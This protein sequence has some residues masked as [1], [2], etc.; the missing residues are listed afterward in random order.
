MSP[1]KFQGSWHQQDVYTLVMR[2]VDYHYDFFHYLLNEEKAQ[3]CLRDVKM[4]LS[5]KAGGVV[6]CSNHYSSLV[7]YDR[8]IYVSYY[9]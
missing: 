5:K 8:L 3:A 1:G 6:R 4:R 9:N 2:M 7:I